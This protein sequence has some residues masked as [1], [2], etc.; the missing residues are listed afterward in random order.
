MNN[1]ECD[2]TDAIQG[3]TPTRVWEYFAEFAKV[4]RCSKHEE[5]ARAYVLGVAKRLKLEART[6]AVGNVVVRKPATGGHARA[7]GLALQGHL[8]MVCEKNKDKVHDFS[9]DPIELVRKGDYVMANGT[10]L[11]A[12]NGIAVATCLALMED[13]SLS[14]GPL[15]F[16]FTIDEETGLTG[17]GG[18]PSDFLESR[19][20]L[21]LD[22]EE[23]GS[24]YV[25]CSGG[26]DTIGTW[27]LALD[28][29]PA[30]TSAAHVLVTGLKGGHSGLEIDK[31]RGNAIKILNRALMALDT[32]GG[33]LATL[34][35]GDKHNA[36]P[37]E[38]EAL[39]WVPV[40]A[41]EEA[42]QAVARLDEIVR[43]ELGAVDPG[44]Q[45]RLETAKGARKGKVL[46]RAQQKKLLLTIAALPHG[47]IKMSPDIPGLVETS[48]NVAAIALNHGMITL[49]T[50]QRSSVASEI[51]EVCDTVEATFALGGATVHG[52]DGYPGW[53]PD[54]ES[55]IL[56]TA[57]R[58]YKSLF[59]KE[60]E[61]KAI[62]AG[63]ECGI[64]G[65]RI[66]GM[67]MV[68]FGPTLEGVHSPD[69]RLHIGSVER[70]YKF[71]TAILSA[72][73]QAS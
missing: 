11:G 54:M 41:W 17:A 61:I 25:G 16:L 48:T 68:S 13:R 28:P 14:H 35:G 23:E 71:L 21:N 72:V 45:I 1:E 24:L 47:V 69:E 52:T 34:H 26:R 44:V 7:K 46:K 62:H 9:K 22:S 66:P 12:D 8:D 63:L 65:E 56:G 6:D 60:P 51:D 42:A 36:I 27:K 5:K 31:G 49:A 29:V 3:L 43:A 15:E 38:A 40:K 32:L 55:P 30:H 67:D 64:I 53:K 70:F 50:S 37:R 39:V 18:V 4:P 73:A 20:M 57:K 58:T 59:G 10:T 19:M 2:M 33:R